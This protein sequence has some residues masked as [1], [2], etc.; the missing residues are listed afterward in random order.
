MLQERPIPAWMSALLVLATLAAF[1]GLQ[2]PTLDDLP[3]ADGSENLNVLTVLE[4]KWDDDGDWLV[5]SLH[6]EPRVRKPPLTA[7]FSN[8]FVYDSTVERTSDSQPHVRAAAYQQL[9]VELRVPAI[10][11]SA[12]ALLAIFDFGCT[13]G[14]RRAGLTAMVVAASSIL[15]LRF[16][17]AATTDV[18]LLVWVAWTNAMLARALLSQQR[19]G[20]FAAAGVFLGLALMAKGP[21][22][23]AQTVAPALVFGLLPLRKRGAS[24]EGEENA[25][26]EPAGRR[27]SYL[28]PIGIGALLML[29]VAL[30]WPLIVYFQNPAVLQTWLAETSRVGATNLEPN[31]AWNYLAIVPLM[32]PWAIFFVIGI[33]VAAARLGL[34]KDGWTLALIGLVIPITIMVFAPDRKERYLLPLIVPAAIITALPLLSQMPRPKQLIDRILGVLHFGTL[35]LMSIGLLLA[36]SYSEFVRGD[37]WYDFS[38]AIPRALIAAACV[39]VAL[40]LW[41]WRGSFL[42]ATSLIMMLMLVGVFTYGYRDAPQAQPKLHGIASAIL[43]VANHDAALEKSPELN[44]YYYDPRPQPKPLPPDLAIYLGRVVKTVQ[45]P[46]DLPDG[47]VIVM[48]QRKNEEAPPSPMGWIPMTSA[49]EPKGERVWHAL[50]RDPAEDFDPGPQLGP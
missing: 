27:R 41:N 24:V 22:A 39:S 13:V 45:N 29:A 47:S 7:W 36:A 5:P 9:A 50:W 12:L 40:L 38:Y 15:L 16:G 44:V 3:F 18:Q 17:R 30:P 1:I 46:D 49:P 26:T 37:A 48:L 42:P 23:L 2:L 34:P 19:W 10:L 28:L 20:G 21:V 6:G 8:L 25:S 11:L 31:P 14:G 4:M 43:E 32:L 33:I 35:A